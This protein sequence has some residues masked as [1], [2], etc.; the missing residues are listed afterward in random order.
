MKSVSPCTK[1]SEGKGRSIHSESGLGG[2]G[3]LRSYEGLRRW[4]ESQQGL[5]QLKRGWEGG[6]SGAGS[7]TLPF[8]LPALDL[9]A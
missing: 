6:L 8:S 9:P 2:G 1:G 4:A 7:F 5:L 3:E